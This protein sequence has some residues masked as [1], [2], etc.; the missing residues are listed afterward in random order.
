MNR[1][2]GLL[3]ASVQ[4][5]RWGLPWFGALA[6]STGLAYAVT[7]T[8]AGGQT[9]PDAPTTNVVAQAPAEALASGVPGWSKATPA[10]SDRVYSDAGCDTSGG[11]LLY[12]GLNS[13]IPAEPELAPCLENA[14]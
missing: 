3:T 7:A 11:R 5:A 13:W 12:V 9:A 10:L 2:P 6:I 4:C 1:T 8:V 14:P